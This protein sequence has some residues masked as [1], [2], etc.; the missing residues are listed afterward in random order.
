[1]KE[2]YYVFSGYKQRNKVCLAYLDCKLPKHRYGSYI[3]K[4]KSRKTEARTHLETKKEQTR[5]R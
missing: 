1:M 5:Y 4:L 3:F 2:K